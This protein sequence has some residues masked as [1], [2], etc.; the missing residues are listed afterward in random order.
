[1]EENKIYPYSY[2]YPKGF[3]DDYVKIL[4]D[5]FC[6]WGRCFKG[7]GGCAD[8]SAR[9][10]ECKIWDVLEIIRKIDKILIKN[11]QARIFLETPNFFDPEKMIG[12]EMYQFHEFL[13][14]ETEYAYLSVQAIPRDL[15]D[16]LKEG[17][18]TPEIIR[19]SGI[20]EIWLG[21]ESANR[22]LRN[23]YWK[24]PFQND[25]LLEMLKQLRGAGINY[26]FYLVV[27]LEDTDETINE[28][29]AF[30]KKLSRIRSVLPICFVIWMANN[31]RTGKA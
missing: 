1:M 12:E 31:M 3:M 19:E 16:F 5:N 17:V 30:I 13:S 6:S 22:D 20:R 9:Y 21:L 29:I 18:V 27:S 28:T 7:Y 10:E 25:D 14:V 23:K 8:R 11:P 2:N 15:I 24:P 4:L 26:C